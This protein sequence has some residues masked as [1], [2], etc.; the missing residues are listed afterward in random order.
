MAKVCCGVYGKG[1]VFSVDLESNADVEALQKVIVNEKKN[2]NDRFNVD[3]SSLTLYLARKEGE[4]T[5]CL[6]GGQNVEDLLGGD[7]DATYQNMFSWWKLNKKEL[8]GS[9]FTP[10]E[11]EIHVLVELPKAATCTQYDD[12]D[13]NRLALYREM[14][15][16]YNKLG[17]DFPV[18]NTEVV[19]VFHGPELENRYKAALHV[20]IHSHHYVFLLGRLKDDSTRTSDPLVM[21]T[22]VQIE[23]PAIFCKCMEWKHKKV[24]Q[25]RRDYFA[26][27][28]AVM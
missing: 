13:N 6:S 11:E 3:P 25:L 8:F 18:V 2:V 24:E 16:A 14:H 15:G 5:K 7:I 10:G 1:T 21:E 26:M 4:E 28:S 27:T 17:F 9:D 20:S 12:D 22:F 23:D 19:S